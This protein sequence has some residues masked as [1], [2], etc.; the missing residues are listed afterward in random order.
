M[1][2]KGLCKASWFVTTA[3]H[4]HVQT[5]LSWWDH[6]P[7]FGQCALQSLAATSTSFAQ[8]CHALLQAT[9]LQITS[10]SGI[11]GVKRSAEMVAGQPCSLPVKLR[12]GV[13]IAKSRG[14]SLV[15]SDATLVLYPSTDNTA[16][17]FFLSD[18]AL[19]ALHSLAWKRPSHRVLR[20]EWR[21]GHH[22]NS[23]SFCVLRLF[24]T[25]LLVC[26]MW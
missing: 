4:T 8:P 7:F 1:G 5:G 22:I 14:L 15:A 13:Y 17:R 9:Q 6:W 12:T 11:I 24:A 19:T 18:A 21:W 16:P 2:S 3:S 25:L 26:A 10:A 23:T 20:S